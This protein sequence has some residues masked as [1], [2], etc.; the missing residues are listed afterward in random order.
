MRNIILLF[1]ILYAQFGVA[2]D[3]PNIIKDPSLELRFDMR[4]N[5]V[6]LEFEKELFNLDFS[7]LLI[8]KY[9]KIELF[10]GIVFRLGENITINPSAGIEYLF[11]EHNIKPRLRLS[12]KFENE[13]FY[14]LVNYGSDWGTSDLTTKIAYGVIGD[15][16]QIGIASINADVGPLVRMKIRIGK[17]NPKTI[18]TFVSYIDEQARLSIRFNIR[19]FP[20]LNKLNPFRKK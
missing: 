11:E 15:R 12:T 16:L 14:M 19:D 1:S 8:L 13:R 18:K 4:P 17:E 6:R 20:K 2:Q 7:T 3:T 5:Q 10:E 9:N